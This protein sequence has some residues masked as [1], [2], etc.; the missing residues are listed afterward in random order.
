MAINMLSNEDIGNRY[1]ELHGGSLQWYKLKYQCTQA[2]Q[3][4]CKNKL[5]VGR[6]VQYMRVMVEPMRLAN[7]CW[8]FEEMGLRSYKIPMPILDEII[9]DSGNMSTREGALFYWL[10]KFP[11]GDQQRFS[12][13]L[14]SIRDIIV[15]LGGEI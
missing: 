5:F 3:S 1:K 15:E 13:L 8:V 6:E 10:I 2:L 12:V 7:L 14:E 4:W 11:V 9:C